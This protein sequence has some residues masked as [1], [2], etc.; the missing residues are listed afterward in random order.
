MVW[1]GIW[2][3]PCIVSIKMTRVWGREWDGRPFKEFIYL[4][5]FLGK[6][7]RMGNESKNI[8]S[9]EMNKIMR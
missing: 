5:L 9:K 2:Y 7:E 4:F 6:E 3:I 1:Y 8:F